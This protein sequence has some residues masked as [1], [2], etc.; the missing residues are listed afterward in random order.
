M[1]KVYRA[2][3]TRLNRN[4]AIKILPT[5]F[6][7]DPDRLRR[8]EGEARAIAALSHPNIVAIF[9]TGEFEGSPYLVSELLEGQTL[10][11]RLSSG[12]LPSRKAVEYALQVAQGLATAHEKGIVHRDLKPENLFIT[13]DNRVK[14]LD[15]GL[16]KLTRVDSASE[17]VTHTIGGVEI[18]ATTPGLVLGTIGYLSP[19]QVRGQPADHRSD[20]FSLGAILYEML[21]GQR[22]FKRDSTA[23][24]LTAILKEDP[25]DLTKWDQKISLGLE[26][27]V[28]HCLEKN[29]E[30][31]FQS[32]RDLAFD[33]ASLSDHSGPRQESPRLSLTITLIMCGHDGFPMASIF[34]S[35]VMSPA[36]ERGFTFRLGRVAN[37][38]PSLSKERTFLQLPYHP[39]AGSWQRSG[40]MRRAI[41]TRLPAVIRAESPDWNRGRNLS[42]GG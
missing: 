9:D 3:D 25:A 5:S 22:A 42:T 19:E 24:T 12:T 37:P 29:P 7:G 41:S 20:I 4:V 28:R 31:R 18:V 40:Q 6:S 8:F 38:N 17:N 1:G 26:R 2:R 32:V 39:T 36:R 34:S 30:E 11:D 23:E 21:S 33:L 10:R 13:R 15:F 16:A 35:R 14:I 27:I